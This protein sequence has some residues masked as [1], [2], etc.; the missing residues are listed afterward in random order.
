MDPS[1]TKL[2]LADAQLVIAR[3]HGFESWPRFSAHLLTLQAGLP[4]AFEE[5]IRAGEV[6]L[7]VEV[8]W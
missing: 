2:K 1:T 4:D 5:L 6:E 3:E 8:A 7:P